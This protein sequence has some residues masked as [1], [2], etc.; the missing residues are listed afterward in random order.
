MKLAGQWL[1]F[2]DC[3][4]VTYA[5]GCNGISNQEYTA[6]GMSNSLQSTYEYRVLVSALCDNS[7]LSIEQRCIVGPPGVAAAQ[8]RLLLQAALL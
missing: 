3:S 5:S 4:K 6:A 7:L 8:L 2:L 1:S